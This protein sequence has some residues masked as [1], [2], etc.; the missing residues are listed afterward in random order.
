MDVL[1]D[2]PRRSGE[3]CFWNFGEFDEF[4]GFE[5][6]VVVLMIV[7]PIH[8]HQAAAVDFILLLQKGHLLLILMSILFIL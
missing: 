5:E 2:L 3:E 8:A 7:L 4:N 1:S 6:L